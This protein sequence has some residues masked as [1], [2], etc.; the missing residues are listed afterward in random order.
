MWS[1]SRPK[2][3]LRYAPSMLQRMLSQPASAASE[4]S[5]MGSSFFLDG[6]HTITLHVRSV[7]GTCE[8][9]ACRVTLQRKPLFF[10]YIPSYC[11]CYSPTLRAVKK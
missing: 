1:V 6:L 10:H 7:P 8:N 4:L 11:I 3:I 5:G 9:N 2:K